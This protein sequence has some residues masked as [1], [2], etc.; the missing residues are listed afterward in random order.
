MRDIREEL[1][2]LLADM[3]IWK[4]VAIHNEYCE[5]NNMFD[6]YI[7]DMGYFEE[8]FRDTAPMDLV[9]KVF[10]GDFNPNDDYYRYDW[11]DNLESAKNP[12]AMDWIDKDDIIEYIIDNDDALRNDDI[13]DLLDEIE[14]ENEEEEEEEEEDE[15]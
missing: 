7:Y 6:D 8:D 10:N 13:R 2:E 1:V 5:K 3:E 4:V 14:A 11:R 15:E 9:K 12:I